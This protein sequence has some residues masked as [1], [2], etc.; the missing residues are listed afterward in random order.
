MTTDNKTLADAQPG[1]RVRL[2]DQ[3]FEA[4]ALSTGLT[5]N[6]LRKLEGEYVYENVRLMCVAWQAALS[7]Q[8]SPGG[9]GDALRVIAERLRG[10]GASLPAPPITGTIEGSM[11][12][13]LSIALALVEEALAARQPSKQLDSVALGEATEFCIEKGDGQPVGEQRAALWIQFAE[14]GNIRFWTKDQDRALAESFL[15]ARPLTAF[16]ASPQQPVQAVDLGPDRFRDPDHLAEWLGSLVDGSE[17]EEWDA[18]QAA[19]IGVRA[20]QQHPAVIER[21]R[22]AVEGECNGLAIT[23]EQAA[24]IFDHVLEPSPLIDSHAV[25]K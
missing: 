16:Y 12:T 9:Q 25:G 7:A 1:G 20:F 6:D 24:A 3:R 19:M 10:A 8:P 23:A 22:E 13:G 2:G 4:W 14:N 21:L 5:I 17:Q 15:H 11:V 18:A